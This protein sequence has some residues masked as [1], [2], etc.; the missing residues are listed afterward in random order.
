MS[1]IIRHLLIAKISTKDRIK[2]ST[3]LNFSVSVIQGSAGPTGYRAVLPEVVHNTQYFRAFDIVL[4]KNLPNI[5]YDVYVPP[6]PEQIPDSLLTEACIR[7]QGEELALLRHRHEPKLRL[8][9]F[10][11]STPIGRIG[12]ILIRRIYICRI[13]YY[14]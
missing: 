3:I 13:A 5:L 1:K 12:P 4:A 11:P 14:S 6:L 8:L 7:H 9:A 10:I 2:G